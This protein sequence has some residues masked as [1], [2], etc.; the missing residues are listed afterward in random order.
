MASASSPAKVKV[1][2]PW[3][4]NGPFTLVPMEKAPLKSLAVG[5]VVSVQEE[6]W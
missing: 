1:A 4:T 2:S 6:R 3:A 5:M